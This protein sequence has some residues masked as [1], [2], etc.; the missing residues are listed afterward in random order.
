MRDIYKLMLILSAAAMCDGSEALLKKDA[1]KE[2]EKQRIQE[3]K[4]K[5]AQREAETLK[6]SKHEDIAKV[7]EIGY[8]RGKRGQENAFQYLDW[9]CNSQII[10]KEMMAGIKSCPNVKSIKI[11]SST[12]EKID[13]GVFEDFDH[14]YEIDLSGCSKLNMID[15]NV[16]CRCS[17]LCNIRLPEALKRIGDRAFCWCENIVE[18]S[19]PKSIEN[20]GIEAFLGAGKLQKLDLSH[21][22][23]LNKIDDR[24]F[25]DCQSL[26]NV[27]LNGK[28][29]GMNVF[30]GCT[31][32][33]SVDFSKCDKMV[34]I[35]NGVFSEYS[36]D[37]V[38]YPACSKLKEVDLS[39][40]KD[41]Q[42]ISDSAFKG[43]RN[44]QKVTIGAPMCSVGNWAFSGCSALVDVDFFG[45]R[46]IG[47]FAFC[48]SGV[49]AI[50]LSNCPTLTKIAKS[51]FEGCIRLKAVKLNEAL[52][53]I[54]SKAFCG[55]KA[56]E[57]VKF[58]GVEQL[59]DIGEFAF[60]GC[61][62]LQKVNL[63]GCK[64][65]TTIHKNAF[66]NCKNLANVS[67]GEGIKIIEDEAFAGCTKL[68]LEEHYTPNRGLNAFPID[69]EKIGKK[70]FSKCEALNISKLVVA[71]LKKE[72][73]KVEAEN[74]INDNA[75]AVNKKEVENNIG[76]NAN[77]VKKK[78]AENNIGDNAFEGCINLKLKELSATTIG[79]EVFKGA[80]IEDITVKVHEAG[81]ECFADCQN[82]TRVM[83]ARPAEWGDG[84]FK[85]CTNLKRVEFD[86]DVTNI[87]KSMFENCSA[88]EIV[89]Y[90]P[91]GNVFDYMTHVEYGKY[92]IPKNLR[93]FLGIKNIAD[94]A[95]KGCKKLAL[96]AL[97]YGNGELNIGNNAFA[98]CEKIGLLATHGISSAAPTE[99]GANAFTGCKK[100]NVLSLF[101]VKKIGNNAFSGCESFSKFIADDQHISRGFRDIG[102]GA[103]S[104]SQIKS[105]D[106][107]HDK[108]IDIR[109]GAFQNRKMLQSTIL[110]NKVESIGDNAYDG[111]TGL[112][113]IL[114]PPTLTGIGN[115]AF[116]G[117]DGLTSLT[118]PTNVK[119]IGENAFFGCNNIRRIVCSAKNFSIISKHLRYLKSLKNII[120]VD[121]NGVNSES[122]IIAQL[123]LKDGLIKLET[124]KGNEYPVDVE[125]LKI[126]MLSAASDFT[127]I[128]LRGDNLKKIGPMAFYGMTNLTSIELPKNVEIIDQ[129][130]FQG[131][132]TLTEIIVPEAAYNAKNEAFKGFN[133][134]GTKHFIHKKIVLKKE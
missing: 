43:C 64:K 13:E 66:E 112:K 35:G 61:E 117:C 106:L 24:A 107:N 55:C 96:F 105:I 16:F 125:E 86:Y 115:E 98:G 127:T 52:K 114:L 116:K 11:T 80:G 14:L 22:Q 27:I 4:D 133:K 128:H 78:E 91:L 103:F 46:E 5:K 69:F 71:P 65:L 73:N 94:S 8:I 31:S 9:V 30:S 6:V 90:N 109:A 58:L 82:L 42:Y 40:C 70:A 85:N 67:F 7:A 59:E 19:I 88:L 38:K 48:G 89:C 110:L 123:T 15:K 56:L 95:F 44:L 81:N 63:L 21:C 101:R 26:A 45:L 60:F 1:A 108:I 2:A 132:D 62:S 102:E 29:L 50:D 134:T 41:L 34:S 20:I 100:L 92:G 37:F 17:K 33:E 49:L 87:A 53:H 39:K 111:C 57:G 77:E 79:D 36:C 131:C 28:G 25:A 119:T 122:S 76:D 129:N 74:N 3:E 51:A 124:Y 47:E 99:I 68:N 93:M 32:L 130:A 75:N 72:V 54:E 126:N 97:K 118:I 84:V 120:V 10:T 18:I 113:S 83:L 23:D 121:C 104:G 12:L